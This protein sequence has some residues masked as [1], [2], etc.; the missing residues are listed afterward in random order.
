MAGTKKTSAAE[1][2]EDLSTLRISVTTMGD[3][4]LSAADRYPDTLALVFPDARYTYQELAAQALRRAR[5]LQALGV[6]PRDHVGILMHTCPAFVEIFFAA[7]LCGA[8]VVPINARYRSHELA[9][10][11]ANGDIATLVTTDAVAEQVS[12]VERLSGALPGLAAQADP[13]RLRLAGTP[14]L[15]NI[16]L[17]GKT[18]SPGFL[19]QSEFD[20]L[21]DTIPERDVHL[22]RLGVRVRDVGLMLYTSGTTANPKGCLIT[23]EAQVRNS[24]ALGRHRYRLTHEDRFWSPLPMFHIASVLPML[25]IFDVG[26]TYLTMSYFDAGIALDMLERYEVTAT[27]PCFVTIMQGL[28]YHPNFTRTNLSRIKL[29][30]S[31]FAVQPPAVAESIMRAMPQALQVGSFGMTET[32]GT[33]CTGSPEEAEPLRI[34]RLG[35]PLPGLEVR[36]VEPE[37]GHEAPTG[38]RGEVL[39]RGYSLLEG[40]HKDAEKTAQAI[41]REGWF[42]TGD[43]GSLD[44][45]GT[46]MF[47][48]RYKDMLKVGGE[49]VAAAEIE[50][51][52]GRHPAVKLAQVVGIPDAKYAEVPAAFVE[53]KPGS[54]ATEA[55][56]VSFCKREVAAFKVP[57]VVRFIDDWPMSSSKI[58]KFRLRET[59]IAELGLT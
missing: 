33:V 11:M 48:G 13:R 18:P 23:H 31:N 24:I 57:R 25:A 32:A 44:E 17:M 53:L 5:S 37:S 29:M 58:Q 21:A 7:A 38:Q 3:L 55:E 40:Y 9:Y 49:N 56:L 6:K 50:A 27:Y 59:L 35:K 12:F 4:L 28:I 14:T 47:H 1:G 36:I 19:P 22:A 46:I 52:L 8:V 42:H 26:G 2:G 51:L 39:V 16:V 34:T 10:V 30:N 41:D 20:D 54:S 45:H 43:I 15:R